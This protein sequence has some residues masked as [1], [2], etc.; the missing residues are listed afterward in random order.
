MVHSEAE[1]ATHSVH[2]SLVDRDVFV[3]GLLCSLKNSQKERLAPSLLSLCF[4]SIKLISEVG[5]RATEDCFEMTN[6]L[7]TAWEKEALEEEYLTVPVTSV[8]QLL[9]YDSSL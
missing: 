1:P 3:S 9:C 7:I 4:A 2:S 5:C 6:I 8:L